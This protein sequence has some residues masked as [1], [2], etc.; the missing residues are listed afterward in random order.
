MTD[1]L[2]AFVISLLAT[3]LLSR[4]IERLAESLPLKD[5]PDARKQHGRARPLGGVAIALG[6]PL[7][8][9][10]AL[11]PAPALWSPFLGGLI[12]GIV[13]LI[14]DLRRVSPKLR[15]MAQ[16]TASLVPI[17][18][19]GIFITS[20]DL[21]GL[22]IE[23]GGWGR[24]LAALWIVGGTNA[25]N[26]ID[27][28]DG[29]AAGGAAIV[30]GFVLYLSVAVGNL[31]NTILTIALLG[32]LLGFLRYNYHPARV[33]MGDAGSTFVGFV[34]SILVLEAFQP[35]YE[36]VRELPILAPILILGLPIFDTFLAIVRR[37]RAGRSIFE[38]DLQ[39]IH[40]KLLSQ[41]W[42]YR[43]TVIILYLIFA[44]FGLFG[45][46]VFWLS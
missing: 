1:Y 28:L 42:G 39:H 31:D 33:F 41:G 38:A 27:G 32:A 24:L 25:F 9:L 21:F 43:R 7:G 13:S 3:L 12:I 8:A 37:V 26:L 23:L 17:F 2:L 34:I 22:Q 15:L 14:D 10:A 45:L 4:I 6:T 5:F 19:G 40:H 11:A 16:I 20:V 44:I 46:L 29:L 18:L 36:A 30:C 35:E